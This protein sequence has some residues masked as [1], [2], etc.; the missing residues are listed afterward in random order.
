MQSESESRSVMS[1][2]TLWDPMDYTFDAILQ[3][4]ILEWIV[5]PFSRGSSQPSNRTGI[6]CIAGRFF[7]NWAMGKP[8]IVLKGWIINN[9]LNLW[10][11]PNLEN[12]GLCRCSQGSQGEFILDLGWAWPPNIGVCVQERDLRCKNRGEGHVR[13]ET[14]ARVMQTAEAGGGKDS[15]QSLR[16]EPSPAVTPWFQTPALQN[17]ERV[18]FCLLKLPGL[19]WF[20]MTALG[21]SCVCVRAQSLSRAR[22]F[23]TP[24]TV[25]HQ[26]PLSMGFPRQ[27][28]WSGL[29]FPSPGDLPNPGIEPSCVSYISSWIFYPCT[30]WEAQE[31]HIRGR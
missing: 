1:V 7:T 21:N 22:P 15:P 24:W 20:V 2:S 16:R 9:P 18:N 12:K 26:T 8:S 27:E 29:P 28:Y 31:S 14:E 4:R 10:M 3:T 25:A 11:W 30:T 17:C 19:W 6:S 23:A 5:F 13:M